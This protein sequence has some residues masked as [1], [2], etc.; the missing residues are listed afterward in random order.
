[1]NLGEWTLKQ[2]LTH[3]DRPFLKEGD[4][5]LDN[6]RFNER[7]DQTARALHSL[8]VVR[9]TGWPSSWPTRR[10]FSNSSSP[11]PRWTP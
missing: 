1:M 6:R 9:E 11:V 2:A 7:V 8:G 5:I 4:R 10:R 3:P